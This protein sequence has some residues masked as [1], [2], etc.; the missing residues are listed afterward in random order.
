M[1]TDII[2][3]L[4]QWSLQQILDLDKNGFYSTFWA[5]L[6]KRVTSVTFLPWQ[7]YSV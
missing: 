1:E 4:S 5:A 7:A 2:L 3:A 6:G